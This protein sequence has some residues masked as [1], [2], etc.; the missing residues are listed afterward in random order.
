[1]HC[2]PLLA[3]GKNNKRLNLSVLHQYIFCL[4]DLIGATNSSKPG[5]G[6]LKGSTWAKA[7]NL[8]TIYSSHR[9]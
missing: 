2:I 5:C 4:I 1:M 7:P 9:K 3:N 6:I 8:W